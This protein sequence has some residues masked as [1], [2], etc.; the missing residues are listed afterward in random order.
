MPYGILQYAVTDRDTELRGPAL[1]AKAKVM[2]VTDP[3]DCIA[4]EEPTKG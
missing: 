1:T 2:P 3:A 4:C